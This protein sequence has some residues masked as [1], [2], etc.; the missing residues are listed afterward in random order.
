[1]FE[2]LSADSD[3]VWLCNCEVSSKRVLAG[4]ALFAPNL[5]A[6]IDLYNAKGDR[7]CRI[8]VP[9]EIR[10]AFTATPLA[11]RNDNIEIA[12]AEYYEPTQNT[13]HR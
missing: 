11:S 3:Q 8:I 4:L 1:M 5:P 12:I 9:S 13:A 6:E 10:Q 2:T 7:V